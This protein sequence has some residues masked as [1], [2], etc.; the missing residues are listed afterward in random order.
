MDAW[1]RMLCTHGSGGSGVRVCMGPA[2]IAVAGCRSLPTERT[3]L[4]HSSLPDVCSRPALCSFYSPHPSPCFLLALNALN[5]QPLNHQRSRPPTSQPP[6]SQ[7]PTSQPPISQPPTSQPLTTTMAPIHKRITGTKEAVTRSKSQEA[8]ANEAKSLSMRKLSR[9]R[10]QGRSLG[11]L[12]A[13]VCVCG[14][15]AFYTVPHCC[16]HPLLVVPKVTQALQRIEIT[17]LNNQPCTVKCVTSCK[18]NVRDVMQV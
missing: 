9:G 14:G 10:F 1:R 3:H 12:R 8:R 16:P 13:C 11:H 7:P 18:S 2:S 17:G 15:S 5:H 4:L 6:T